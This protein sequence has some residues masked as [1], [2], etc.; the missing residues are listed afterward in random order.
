[1]EFLPSTMA[2]QPEPQG[3]VL[4]ELLSSLWPQTLP[5]PVS[6]CVC[7]KVFFIYWRERA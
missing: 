1:M 3:F 6:V 7:F 2:Q 4:P 5:F